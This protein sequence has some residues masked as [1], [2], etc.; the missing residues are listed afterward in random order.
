MEGDKQADC[1]TFPLTY[2][3]SKTKLLIYISLGISAIGILFNTIF[4]AIYTYPI[5]GLS[6]EWI[7]ILSGN[8]ILPML[9]YTAVIL[10]PRMASICISTFKAN[11]TG[12]FRQVSLKLKWLMILG[13]IGV[14]FTPI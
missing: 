10:A 12:D 8:S 14:L 3:I 2:G 5:S 7:K 6:K 1:N 9:I 11:S 4:Q 13:I